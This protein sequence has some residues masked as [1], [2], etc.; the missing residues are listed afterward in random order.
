MVFIVANG[1]CEA[2]SPEERGESASTACEFKEVS[3]CVIFVFADRLGW[4]ARQG[5]D[6]TNMIEISLFQAWKT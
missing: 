3:I 6:R 2:R 5:V 1:L 4:M